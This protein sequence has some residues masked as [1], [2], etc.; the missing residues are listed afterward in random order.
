MSDCH[1]ANIDAGV[2]ESFGD[3]WSRFDQSKLD[4]KDFT[5]IFTNYFAIFPWETLPE[6]AVGFDLG[7][8]SGR[9]AKAVAPNVGAL[10]C[11]DPSS[12]LEIAKANLSD[13]NNCFFHYAGVDTIPLQD[14]SAD[15]GYSLGVLYRPSNSMDN[16]FFNT[17]FM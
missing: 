3:E 12:A 5:E 9:W 16:D 10:H 6:N 8:G 17:D 7:C 15:F 14:N 2:V 4:E 11:I 1:K 13:H